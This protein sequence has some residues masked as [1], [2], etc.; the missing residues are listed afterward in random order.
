MLSTAALDDNFVSLTIVMLHFIAASRWQLLLSRHFIVVFY[1]F[2]HQMG[3][4]INKISFVVV[5]FSHFTFAHS[6]QSLEIA[7]IRWT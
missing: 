1:R 7:A 2:Y 4:E 3:E 6:M 5:P